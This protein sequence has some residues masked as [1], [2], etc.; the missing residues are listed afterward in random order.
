MNEKVSLSSILWHPLQLVYS[1][2]LYVNIDRYLITEIRQLL[3]R[4]WDLPWLPLQSFLRYHTL[5]DNQ[6][7]T[8][9]SY[10]MQM[11]F[12]TDYLTFIST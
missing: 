4:E 8:L 6:H 2:D 11:L 5:C 12:L 1:Y 7:P 3:I 9:P 10:N